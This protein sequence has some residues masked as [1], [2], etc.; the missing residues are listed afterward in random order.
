MFVFCFLFFVV[1]SW[2]IRNIFG[3]SSRQKQKR[4][5]DI[6]GEVVT[7]SEHDLEREEEIYKIQHDVEDVSE[8]FSDMHELVHEQQDE[9]SV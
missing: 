5:E 3:G 4:F 8:M 9:L 7:H 1:K 6:A 2:S